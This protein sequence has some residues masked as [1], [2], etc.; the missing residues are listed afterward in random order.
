MIDKNELKKRVSVFFNNAFINNYPIVTAG[1]I[2]A[3]LLIFIILSI[4]KQSKENIVNEFQNHQLTSVESAARG[5]EGFIKN[6]A[7]DL[8]VI[9]QLRSVQAGEL[10]A[11]KST[12]ENLYS[13]HKGDDYFLASLSYFD[14]KGKLLAVAP[15]ETEGKEYSLAADDLQKYPFHS[16]SEADFHISG[17]LFNEE[18][19]GIIRISA[20]VFLDQK[21]VQPGKERLV[22]ILA[23]CIDVKRMTDYFMGHVNL[24]GSYVSILDTD[25]TIIDHPCP[26][27]IERNI[28]DINIKRIDEDNK[29]FPFQD[30]RDILDMFLEG[31][32]GTLRV[33]SPN[34]GRL[35]LLA[36]APVRLYTR[37]WIII[38]FTPYSEV[39]GPIG[40]LQKQFT[41]IMLGLIILMTAG[42]F[43]FVTANKKR[44]GTEL[45][46]KLLTKEIQLE[47]K[48]KKSE[49]KLRAILHSLNDFIIILDRD[50]N[51]IWSND[52]G[53]G[54][55]LVGK[56]C[57]QIYKGLHQPCPQCVVR[58]SFIDAK[59]HLV[60][61]VGQ[62]NAQKFYYQMSSSPILDNEGNVTKVVEMTRDMSDI[63]KMDILVRE[64]EERYR[65]LMEQM[66]EGLLVVD[67]GSRV[68][69]VNKSLCEL[70]HCDR[71]KIINQDY[72]ILFDAANQ[73]IMKK[74]IE[75]AKSRQAFQFELEIDNASGGPIALIG[76]ISA[77]FDERSKYRGASV[78]F[79]EITERKKLAKEIQ[80]SRDKLRAILKSL[81]DGVMI[82]DKNYIVQY[83][84]EASRKIFGDQVSN[85]CYQALWGRP[86]PCEKCLQREIFERNEDLYL[87]RDSLMGRVLDISASPFVMEDGSNALLKVFRDITERKR[88]EDRLFESEQNRLRDLKERYRF[89]NIIGNNHMMQEIYELISI[90]SQNVTTVLIEGASGTGKEL[91]AR[92]IH[93]NSPQHDKPFIGVSCS[94]LP[95]GLLESEL[96]G[97]VRG[98]FT[99]AIRD[100]MGRFELADGGTIFLDEIGDI[101]PLIQ[102]KLL[103]V[104]QERQFERVGSLKTISVN[105]R[106]IA[107]TNKD[108]KAAV[109]KGEFREDLYYRLNVVNIRLPSLRERIDDIPLLVDHFIEKFNKK[110]NKKVR[111]V[112]SGTI[113]ILLSYDWPGNIRQLENVVEHAFIC[114]KNNRILPEDLPL[115]IQQAKKKGREAA[116]GSE[117]EGGNQGKVMTLDDMEAQ[118]IVN[119]LHQTDGHLGNTAQVLGIARSTLWRLMK[120]HKINKES[121]KEPMPKVVSLEEKL[122]KRN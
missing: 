37:S 96:F 89:G 110:F 55:T 91:I 62:D 121:I 85:V 87:T 72:G 65:N 44:I 14:A 1:I 16:G 84:N 13:L 46:V 3:I 23:A 104:L 38:M 114:A 70:M 67:A 76:S 99:G 79:T 108:L 7:K 36:Y 60:E 107:A 51:I 35:E 50:L 18:R 40:E 5:I 109:E 95:D 81:S 80:L 59:S 56:K 25:G 77:L 52:K 31:R 49:A 86:A 8:C 73:A 111:S 41:I 6:I 103:R 43:L 20:P 17:L 11:I 61:V 58:E 21:Y 75:E 113:D 74:A 33:I 115:E 120:K 32:E 105:V 64:S 94:A 39:L 88:L 22:G 2:V 66:N 57:Y 83:M 98:S 97:H 93:Y 28:R 10:A 45:R 53:D 4:Y 47:E 15:S 48:I 102:V 117:L 63:R 19:E 101:S 112:S 42:S 118:M 92:A 27:F 116:F 106:V 54:N 29:V 12:L 9:R 26:Q 100:K 90:V 30:S 122:F 68:T 24:H 119:A 34:L 78:V 82:I 69:F 71:E